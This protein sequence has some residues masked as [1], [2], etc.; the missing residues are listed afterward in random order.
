MHP[1]R[2]NLPVYYRRLGIVYFQFGHMNQA[3]KQFNLA[4]KFATKGTD[5]YNHIL[6]CIGY[7]YVKIKDYKKATPYFQEAVNLTLK[8]DDHRYLKA[9]YE[10]LAAIQM[11]S[12]G[13][14]PKKRLILVQLLKTP[15][16]RTKSIP[17][18][19]FNMLLII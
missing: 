2:K 8:S 11:K 4:L 1:D 9:F 10:N 13:M 14:Q 16:K 7:T 15:R 3:I 6:N 19:T 12:I 18:M 5:I 17:I